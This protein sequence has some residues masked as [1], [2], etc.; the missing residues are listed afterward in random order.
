MVKKLLKK[1]ISWVLALL[2]LPVV[3]AVAKH[4]ALMLPMLHKEGWR[5]WWLYGAGILTYVLIEALFKKPM[6]LYVFGHELTH[7]VSGLLTGAKVHSFKASSKGGEVEMSKS[8]AFIALAP[9]VLPLY[10]VV[11]IG[12][13]ALLKIWWPTQHLHQGFQFLLGLTL[14]FH[15]SLTFH[16][17]HTKQPD[18][19]VLGLFLSVVVIALGNLLILGLLGVS[20]FKK[21]PSLAQ[22]RDSIGKETVFAMKTSVKFMGDLWTRSR[23]V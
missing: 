11:V 6:W 17:V 22:Y 8:N 18:L 5:S 12:L 15:I 16:A 9:Y 1:G 10:M 20:L 23:T 13:Y 19:K 4:T 2:L 21:T 14:A 7:A 3:W